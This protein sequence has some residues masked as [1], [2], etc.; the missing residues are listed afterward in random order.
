MATYSH[1][2]L[3]KEGVRIFSEATYKE[4]LTLHLLVLTCASCGHIIS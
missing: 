4:Q 1:E 2:I 3:G